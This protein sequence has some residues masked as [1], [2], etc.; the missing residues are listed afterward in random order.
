[1]THPRETDQNFLAW[2]MTQG[3]DNKRAMNSGFRAVNVY[4]LM[5]VSYLIPPLKY[6]YGIKPE[7]VHLLVPQ[8]VYIE[9]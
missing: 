2:R 8:S 5:L 6:E 1:M 9:S 7:Y 3:L 4:Q